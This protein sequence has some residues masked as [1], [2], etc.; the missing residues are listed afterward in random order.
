MIDSIEPICERC[1]KCCNTYSFWMTNRSFDND[2]DEIKRLATYH[3][4][5]LMKH[6][7]TGELG[8]K[9]PMT[10]KHLGW[11]DG[12]SFCKIYKTRPVVC[13]KYFCGKAVE[14]ALE[15]LNGICV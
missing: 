10:C 15:K 8:L 5:E 14:L 2:P 3:G 6:R 1:G 9:I 11:K 12:K 7:E 4:L 13:K